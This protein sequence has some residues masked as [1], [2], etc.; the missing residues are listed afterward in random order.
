MSVLKGNWGAALLGTWGVG[1]RVV[2]CAFL[3]LHGPPPS[4]LVA[5]RLLGFG[6]ALA[7]CLP[8]G[9]PAV[10]VST[11]WPEGSARSFPNI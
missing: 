1:W 7:A 4:P 5:P 3:V 10:E 2:R 6:S 11:T 9:P 8:P